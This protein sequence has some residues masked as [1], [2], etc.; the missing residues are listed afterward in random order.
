MPSRF[1]TALR[2]LLRLLIAALQA[3]LM[4]WAACLPLV[5][6]LRDGLGPDATESGGAEAVFKVAIG[7]GVPAL[8]LALPLC[9]LLFVDRRGAAG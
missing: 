8:A 9:G 3:G 1:N 6:V 7:W 5:W 2:V 4:V